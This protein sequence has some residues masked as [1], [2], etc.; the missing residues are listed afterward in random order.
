M[1]FP[2]CVE[3]FVKFFENFDWPK[4]SKEEWD[5]NLQEYRTDK[6]CEKL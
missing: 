5:E 4:T 3:E 6:N 1:S 2:L